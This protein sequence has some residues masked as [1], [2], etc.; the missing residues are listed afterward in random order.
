MTSCLFI[1]QVTF[2]N[3]RLRIVIVIFIMYVRLK[4]SYFSGVILKI[5][6]RFLSSFVFL[7]V[8]LMLSAC[9]PEVGSE[10]WCED[11]KEKDKGDWTTNE[12]SDY[13]KHCMF[14]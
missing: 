9:A 7:S 11:L 5:F 6:T 8:V 12:M 10:E 13:A 4:N 14:K 1:N 3:F 2:L